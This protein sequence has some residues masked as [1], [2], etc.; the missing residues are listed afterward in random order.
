M[1]FK[2]ENCFPEWPKFSTGLT[3]K[4]CQVL[5][6]LQPHREKRELKKWKGKK[7]L[8]HVSKWEGVIGAWASLTTLSLCGGLCEEEEGGVRVRVYFNQLIII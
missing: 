6:T 1:S 5:A 7:Q 2:I 4:F 3:G 8:Y